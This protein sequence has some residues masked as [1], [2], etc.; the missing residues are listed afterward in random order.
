MKIGKIYKIVTPKSNDCYIGSTFDKIKYRFS[1]HKAKY[2]IWKEKELKKGCSVFDFFDEH[3]FENCKILLIK[4]YEV[5]DRKHLEVYETLWIKKL[6]S[7]NIVEPSGGILKNTRLE[8]Y[9]Q[10]NKAKIKQSREKYHI[11][12][13]ERLNQKSKEYHQKNRDSRN[14]KNKEYYKENKEKIILYQKH[15][16]KENKD[17][18]RQTEKTYYLNNRELLNQKRKLYREAN[19]NKLNQK[20]KEKIKCETCNIEIRKDCLKRHNKTRKH[21]NKLQ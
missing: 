14:Q 9:K 13:R 18:V 7:I 2:K 8:Q 20:R 1:N 21:L 17:K 15:Y 6:K 4:E 11:K 10:K 5:I 19:K 16:R 12:N 3:G